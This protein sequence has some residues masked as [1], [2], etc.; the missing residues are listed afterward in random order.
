MI[1]CQWGI[2]EK[3]AFTLLVFRPQQHLPFAHL[4]TKLLQGTHQSISN[5]PHSKKQG[6]LDFK[7]SLP[8]VS[9][10]RD[11]S[12]FCPTQPPR[13]FQRDW[14]LVVH[15][16]NLFMN[17]SWI[18]FFPLSHFY[19]PLLELPKSQMSY[20]T[21]M[22]VTASPSGGSPPNPNTIS[23]LHEIL[24]MLVTRFHLG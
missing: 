12:E 14:A 9:C 8:S 21:E 20:F 3:D 23:F 13:E 19:A 24:I 6:D 22:H 1:V 18:V 7:Q 4:L 15:R 16:G 2:Q 10:P 11:N 5:Y 17:S